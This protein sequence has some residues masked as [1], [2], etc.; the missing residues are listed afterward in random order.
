MSNES[1]PTVEVLN[2]LREEIATWQATA[3]RGRAALL[4]ERHI[5]VDAL[6]RAMTFEP[7]QYRLE[8]AQPDLVGV[9]FMTLETAL[10]TV[11][12]LPGM[13]LTVHDAFVYAS[14]Q[15]AKAMR[16]LNT[17]LDKEARRARDAAALAA[18]GGNLAR[19]ERAQE[20]GDDANLRA[21]VLAAVVR[22]MGLAAPL[23]GSKSRGELADRLFHAVSAHSLA[24]VKL[25]SEGLRSA[26]Q[27]AYFRRENDAG[28]YGREW[29]REIAINGK[30]GLADESDAALLERVMINVGHDY[31]VGADGIWLGDN[32]SEFLAVMAQEGQV[33]MVRAA[34][35]EELHDYPLETAEA[36]GDRY[37]ELGMSNP[38]EEV[39]L[40]H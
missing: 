4:G 36:L 18:T 11:E 1:N 38:F 32:E 2:V 7:G 25:L 31:L 8:Q 37:I 22:E 34:I 19:A 26:L 14:Q 15:A 20:A 29:R 13:F 28:A 33:E 23:D 40:A 9:S 10:R 16:L 35:V 5:I 3:A 30:R 24:R 39:L 12:G 6:D 17:L 21:R 27:D